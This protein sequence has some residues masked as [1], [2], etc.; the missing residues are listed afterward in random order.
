MTALT[1]S[2]TAAMLFFAAG[3]LAVGFFFGTVLRAE[4]DGRRGARQNRAGSPGARRDRITLRARRATGARHR[5]TRGPGGE[6]GNVRAGDA[7]AG[8][9]GSVP[10]ATYRGRAAV[11][12]SAIDGSSSLRKK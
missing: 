11:I 9:A 8:T 7:R 12:V 2:P 3:C 10:A 4:L 5:P 1:A 6:A